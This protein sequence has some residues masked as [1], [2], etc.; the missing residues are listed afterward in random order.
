MFLTWFKTITKTSGL[1]LTRPQALLIKFAIIRRANG[2]SAMIASSS[3]LGVRVCNDHK[4]DKAWRG[5]QK[6]EIT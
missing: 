3:T 2:L 6:P 4:V 1:C 5:K